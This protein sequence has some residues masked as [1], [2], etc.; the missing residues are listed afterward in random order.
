[1]AFSATNHA[2]PVVPDCRIVSAA[3]DFVI[4]PMKSLLRHLFVS[5]SLLLLS[6]APPISGAPASL[7]MLTQFGY[8]PANPVLVRVEALTAAGERDRDLWDAETT[9]TASG[10]VTLS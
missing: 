1:M 6:M 5:S 7:K 8:L 9:L 10:G 3:H 4:P 2:S